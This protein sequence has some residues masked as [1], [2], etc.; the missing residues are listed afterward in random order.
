MLSVGVAA[1]FLAIPRAFYP[2]D[3]LIPHHPSPV[4]KDLHNLKEL[5]KRKQA[6]MTWCNVKPK[7]KATP[8]SEPVINTLPRFIS[9]IISI[10]LETFCSPTT[11]QNE[12]AVDVTGP[13][14]GSRK[15]NREGGKQLCDVSST[16]MCFHRTRGRGSL[17]KA[18][19]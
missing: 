15:M 5:G 12:C 1:N 16:S 3:T 11:T 7:R 14:I 19:K 6:R 8:H 13:Q 10:L 9:K 18:A 2:F 4:N 17:N